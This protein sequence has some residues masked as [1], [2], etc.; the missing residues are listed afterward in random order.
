VD[1]FNVSAHALGDSIRWARLSSHDGEQ[2]QLPMFEKAGMIRDW[3]KACAWRAPRPPVSCTLKGDY[4]RQTDGRGVLRAQPHR[5]TVP[6]AR[7]P[8]RCRYESDRHRNRAPSPEPQ[9][10]LTLHLSLDVY[11]ARDGNLSRAPRE[12]AQGWWVVML[13]RA[14]HK[15]A[16]VASDSRKE[17]STNPSTFTTT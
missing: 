12:A 10:T 15:P 8:G 1:A 4:G 5:L 14:W 7:A 2:L 16:D 17:D 9:Q 3:G 6:F 13:R 11:V